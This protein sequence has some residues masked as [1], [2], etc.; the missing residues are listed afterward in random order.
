MTAKQYLQQLQRLAAQ[1]WALKDQIEHMRARL[2]ST[3]VP[4][5]QDLVQSSSKGDSFADAIAAMADKALYYDTL[6]YSFEQT[7]QTILD[8]ILGL[9]DPRYI[10]VL[11]LRY[12][13]GK[14]LKQISA[15]MFYAETY[16]ARLLSQAHAAFAKKYPEI[17]RG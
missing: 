14:S 3:T 2:E 13:Q 11:D 1:M 9:D 15:E 16:V 12:V 17:L 6:M 10:T 8:Q 7:R 5:K 4:I